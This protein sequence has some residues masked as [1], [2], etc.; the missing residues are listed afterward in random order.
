MALVTVAR[1]QTL[2][3]DT[4]TEPTLV[5]SRLA[6]AQSYVED[7]LMRRDILE[8]A[9]RTESLVPDR[10]GRLY[11]SATPVTEADG[12]EIDG[13]VLEVSFP[14]SYDWEGSVTVTYT[15]GYTS[16]TVP[17]SIERAIAKIAQQLNGLPSGPIGAKSVTLGDASVT[18]ADSS[19]EF[20]ILNDPV[21]KRYKKKRYITATKRRG[22]W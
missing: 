2:T 1:Y 18:Y 8:S 3:G 14:S 4:T 21:L 11:P 5:L 7:F 9:E 16:A 10:N 6:D 12:Y 17:I 20:E 13:N 22:G 19:K 15:G